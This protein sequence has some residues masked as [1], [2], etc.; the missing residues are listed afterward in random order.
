MKNKNCFA[1]DN[2]QFVDM[3]NDLRLVVIRRVVDIGGLLNSVI[4][5][6]FW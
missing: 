3:F 5:I 6:F 4:Y 1:K 2:K